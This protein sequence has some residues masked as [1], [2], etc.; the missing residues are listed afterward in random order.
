M[1]SP[2]K[3]YVRFDGTGRIVSSSLIYRRKKPLDGNWHLLSEITT[4]IYP[5]PN[6]FEI[7]EI[8]KESKEISCSI[9]REG[10]T[11]YSRGVL[12]IGK[13]VYT[14]YELLIPVKGGNLWY[15]TFVSDKLY[16]ILIDNNGLVTDYQICTN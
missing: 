3:A 2:L 12:E 7:S 16:V 4:T 1:K 6:I 13:I 14:D 9:L 11:S 10:V 8:G 15:N 5:G